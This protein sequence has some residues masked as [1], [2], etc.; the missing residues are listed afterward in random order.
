MKFVQ[1]DV[2]RQYEQS[3][4]WRQGHKCPLQ[5]PKVPANAGERVS[6]VHS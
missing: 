4:Y 3:P 6:C 5:P 1:I 2:I